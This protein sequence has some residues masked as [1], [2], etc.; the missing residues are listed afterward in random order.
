MAVGALIFNFLY[1]GFGFLRMGTT[2]FTAQAHGAGDQAEVAAMLWRGLIGAA[3]FGGA[4][5]VLQTPLIAAAMALMGASDA[6]SAHTR[7]YYAI[8]IWSAPAA[9]A[10]YVILG[11]YLG[12]QNARAGLIIQVVINALNIV[13]DLAFVVGLAMAVEGVA[14]A[15]VIAEY[16]GLALGAVMVWRSQ[17]RLDGR[18]QWSR[19]LDPARFRHIVAVNRDFF[20]R[21]LCLIAAF[22]YLT[23]QGAR[24]GDVI[25]AANAVLFNMVTFM[26]YTL[27]GFA[28]ASQAM[29]GRAVGA[30]SRADYRGAV[31][32]STLWAV[33]FAAALTVAYAVTGSLIVDALTTVPEVRAV[34]YSALPWMVAAP[35][36]SIWSLQLDGIFIGATR[37]AE[38]RNAMIVSLLVYLITTEAFRPMLGN[39]GIWLGF[40]VF[41]ISRGL[42]L[43]YYFPRIERAI[44]AG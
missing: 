13:L 8:R 41:M 43:S 44:G 30:G 24:M 37:S 22:A 11:W 4:L 23:A 36:V 40:T 6:V 29:V 19:I 25:L 38:M 1:W 33:G 16:A 28:G 17:R 26:M 42:T 39:H 12:L 18:A 5:L 7:T 3:I 32:W 21:T 2:G 27:D 31:R 14:L 20:L 15:T 10:N 9:L 34:A 35:V